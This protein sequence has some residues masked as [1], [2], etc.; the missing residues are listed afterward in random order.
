M[1]GNSLPQNPI[2]LSRPG[3]PRDG[4]GFLCPVCRAPLA[5]HSDGEC[6]AAL[7][8]AARPFVRMHRTMPNA[9]RDDVDVLVRVTWQQW[10]TLNW[11]VSQQ[12]R[13]GNNGNNGNH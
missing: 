10:E 4:E 9:A 8:E 3:P 6:I 1:T 5:F 11:M 13:D 12:Q 2:L 7:V